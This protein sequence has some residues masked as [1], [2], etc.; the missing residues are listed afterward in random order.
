[1][2]RA[3]GKQSFFGRLWRNVVNALS[4]NFLG[5]AVEFETSPLLEF[6]TTTL[7]EKAAIKG[8]GVAPADDT[9]G[10]TFGDM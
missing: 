6:S 1:M 8:G 4:K 3:K 10:K 2:P 5:G 7:E 9:P